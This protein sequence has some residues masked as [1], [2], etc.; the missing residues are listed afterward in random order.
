MEDT[1]GEVAGEVWDFLEENGETS[2]SGVTKGVEAP[3]TKVYMAMG[4]LAREDKLEFLDKKR[5]N[6]VRLN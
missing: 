1:I 3:G 5:G 4:W 6:A 2:V